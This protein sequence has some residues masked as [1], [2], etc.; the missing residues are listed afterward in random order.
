MKQYRTIFNQYF[1]RFDI[2]EPN[3]LR[4]FHHSYRVMGYAYNIGE[5]LHLNEHDLWL[6][7]MIGLF[8]DIGRFEQWTQY[9]TYCDQKSI[10]HGLLAYDILQSENIL[11]DI[12]GEDKDIILTAIRNHNQ[13]DTTAIQ[14]ERKL[15]FCK[16]IR[17]A[18]K[19]DILLEQQN[20][21]SKVEETLQT[22]LLDSIY[23]KKQCQNE[24]IK[25]DVDSVLRQIGFL[26]D[27]NFSYTFTYLKEKN[28]FI[29]T[30]N[31][32]EN[33]VT[34]KNAVQELK[35][36]ISEYIKEKEQC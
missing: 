25:T 24:D 30:F 3:I 32:L 35:N 1:K 29:N 6:C 10:D 4:K 28:W 8:H 26:F 15:L 5:S 31:V 11:D 22:K 9:Q 34:D 7:E 16:I 17:D 33:Y 18:D 27:L 36:F 21:I 14:D 12:D 23:H 20:T 19:I 2:K 13:Y